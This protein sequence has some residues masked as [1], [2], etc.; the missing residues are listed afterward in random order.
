M[1]RLYLYK[2]AFAVLLLLFAASTAM[3]QQAVSG[4]VLAADD[5]SPIPGVNVL[6]K[7]T[8]NGTVTD[9]D[10]NYR[11]TVSS[12][13]TL[14]YSFVGYITQELAVGNQSVVDITL[15]SDVTSLNEVVVVG[16]GSQDKKEI[17]GAVVALDPTTFNK[18][19]VNDPTMLLQGKVAGLSIYNKGG[20]PNASPVVRLRGLS[21][22]GS[23]SQPLVV[24][25]GVIGAS[26]DN[27]DPNDIESINVLKDGSAA[28]IYGSRG[29]SGVILVTTKK[30]KKGGLGVD[31][32]GYVAAGTIFKKLPI[33]S[34]DEYLANGGNDLGSNTNWQKEVT[35]TSISNVHNIALS[36]GGQN[37]QFRLSTNFRNQEG[38]MKKTGWDQINSRASLSSTALDGKLHMDFSMSFTNRNSDF[39]FPEAFRYA[40]L[41]NPTAPIHF[42]NGDYYQA[43]LFDNYNPVALIN[44]NVHDG[45]KQTLNYGGKIDYQ[46]FKGLTWT[47]NYGRQIDNTTQNYYYA[48]NS[49]WNGYGRHG[50]A[51]KTSDSHDFS[52]IETYGTYAANVGKLDIVGS[53]GYS[54]QQDQTEGFHAQ[55]GNFPTDIFGYNA[56]G[57]A[58]DRVSG[59]RD[60]VDVDSYKSP[61][62]KIIAGFARVNLTWDNGIFFN[63]SVRQEGSTKLG[64]D[65]RWGTFPALGAGVDLNKYLNIARVNLLKLRVGYGVTGSLPGSTGLSQDAYSYSFTAPGSFG[66]STNGN[67]DLKWEE[68]HEINIGVEF[69]V[70]RLSGTLDVYNR[71]IKN[72][73]LRRAVP[74]TEF[75]SGFQ[76]QNAASLQTPGV[77]LTLNYNDVQVGGVHWTPG[78]VVSH[79]QTKLKSYIIDRSLSN[80][81]FGAPGQNGTYPILLETGKPIGQIWGPVFSGVNVDDVSTT[82]KNEAGTPKFADLNGDGK[83]VA[84]PSDA[85]AKDAD[86]KIL[87]YG[88]PTVEIGWTNRLTFGNWDLNVFFRSALGH[89]LIN[90]YRAFYEPIDPGAINSYNR[91]STSKAVPGLTSAQYSSL[92]VE[93]AS[94]VKLDNATLGYTFK[95]NSKNIRSLR[96]YFSGQNI[97][98]IT[99]Y[100][101]VDPEPSLQDTEQNPQDVLSPG[102]DRR[103]NYFTAR[104]Y[105]FGIQLGLQ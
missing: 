79:Y 54:Y 73:I 59:N 43:I 84:N 76:Y 48:S 13:A 52:L 96:L 49:L 61:L 6:E 78:L 5:G 39:S 36:G 8:S 40:T 22:V 94:F 65:H 12:G 9:G 14:V 42:P 4:K 26:L 62:T 102:F 33:M 82:D 55:L 80:A 83:I 47:V 67:P 11:M 45:K 2:G 66:I 71:T 90:Q 46:I 25:D 105:T 93:N 21:T 53:A 98:Q 81:D 19:N 63:A 18:G 31:Y 56:L 34:H 97:F 24:V 17:T 87:G 68:K 51:Q 103:N 44:Q 91:I 57:T 15:A 77:E 70:G 50:L 16:Y 72:A 101:G 32:N 89:S 35:R 3:A 58:G 30:G 92:Y 41:Y 95:V 74:T 7:G 20:D 85:L 60:R 75:A 64:K 100:T 1:I 69:G 37:T 28:A 10:G 104:T 86:M 29:S 23:N 99:G 27:V 38:I 88:I